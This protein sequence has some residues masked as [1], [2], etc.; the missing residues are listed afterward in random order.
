MKTKLSEIEQLRLKKEEL[1][2]ECQSIELK[3]KERA[4]YTKSNI[5]NLFLN[6]I[7][8][9]AKNGFSGLASSDSKEK[10]TSKSTFGIGQILA[11]SAPFVWEI[12]QPFLL[13]IALKKAKSI[14]FRKKK[15]K[16]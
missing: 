8:S 6:T 7:V 13:G 5:G 10:D 4:N 2:Q 9:S 15:K 11:T 14:L 1:R 12:I 3:L 16:K